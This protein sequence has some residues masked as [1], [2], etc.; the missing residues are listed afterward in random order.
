MYRNKFK[1]R[2]C[3]VDKTLRDV[4][5]AIEPRMQDNGYAN[6]QLAELS[7]YLKIRSC[8]TGLETPK[9]ELALRLAEEQLEAWEKEANKK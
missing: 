8:S 4:L 5:T 2:L 9:C 1:A 6:M 7:Q 3:L